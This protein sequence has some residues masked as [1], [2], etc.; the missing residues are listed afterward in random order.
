MIKKIL[1]TAIS[2]ALIA[3]MA[4]GTVGCA[5][6]GNV[7]DL[8]NSITA[9]HVEGKDA[10]ARFISSQ[11]DFAVALFQRSA[12]EKGENTLISPL[13]VMSALAMT[14]NGA[15]GDT[16]AQMEKVLGGTLTIEELNA[17]LHNYVENL[18]TSEKASFHL[19]NSIWVDE[20]DLAV[21]EKFLQIT[22]D[23]YGAGVYREVFGEKTADKINAWVEEH[24]NGMIKKILDEVSPSTV[25]FLVNALAFEAEWTS[26]YS[27]HAIRTDEFTCADGTK[28]QIQMMHSD[29]SIYLEDK[30]TIGFIKSYAGR[31][32]SFVALLPD[33]DI[34]IEDY[35]AN[36]TGEKLM[37][38]WEN[39]QFTDVI[40]ALPQFEHEYDILLNDALSEMGMPNAFGTNADLSGLGCAM[41]GGDL[42][43]SRVLH[44]TFI[45]VDGLGTK[46]GA[47]TVVAV[48]AESAEIGAKPP[49]TVIL[50]RPFVYMIVHNETGL[51]LFIGTATNL[52]KSGT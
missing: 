43:I 35:V 20:P 24:T 14:A 49:K 41:D 52:G 5:T 3:S 21:S 8:T 50:D 31:E 11:M 37:K 36:L 30:N 26:P 6:S 18:P 32:Y 47:A 2:T 4:L 51:P 34:S 39:K 16:L 19:A 40:A 15:K 46:A 17:Y 28:S 22:A 45:K 13:S 38:L 27:E 25:M 44:K 1:K 7:N 48:D 23:Y 29:E 42:Y 33:E 12:A 9:N 10:D